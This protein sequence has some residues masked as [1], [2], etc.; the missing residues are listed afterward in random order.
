MAE[1]DRETEK[2]RSWLETATSREGAAG[3]AGGGGAPPPV[4]LE[5]PTIV[6][7]EG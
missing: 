3:P 4:L 5:I 6:F 1:G 2:I 7:E